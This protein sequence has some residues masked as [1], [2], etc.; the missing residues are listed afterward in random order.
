MSLEWTG[1]GPG[2]VM[3]VRCPERLPEELY[4]QVLEQMGELLPVVQALPPTAALAD[5][6]GA[7]RYHGATA[8]HLGE[9][10]R[11]RTVSRFGADV[12]VGIGPT[13]SRQVRGFLKASDRELAG[14]LRSRRRS[15]S[16]LRQQGL[17]A[18]ARESRVPVPARA[19]ARA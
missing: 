5:L 14:H 18:C 6:R 3:H 8:S 17:T 10:L 2:V 9:M 15:C 12:R 1:R 11:L 13:R 19:R 4:R 7:L 16:R